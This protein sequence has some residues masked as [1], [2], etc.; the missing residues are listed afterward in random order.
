MRTSCLENITHAEPLQSEVTYFDLFLTHVVLAGGIAIPGAV[1]GIMIGGYLLKR[2]QLGERG[3]ISNS[4]HI[5]VNSFRCR[6]STKIKAK[7]LLE[8]LW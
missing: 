8:F 3:N 6:S 2:C 7:L 1:F 4:N 5:T